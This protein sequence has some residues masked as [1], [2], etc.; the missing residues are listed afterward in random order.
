[1]ISGTLD[2]RLLYLSGSIKAAARGFTKY[3]LDLLEIQELS[4]KK[5]Q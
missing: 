2:V 3:K 5:W 1:M 4:E